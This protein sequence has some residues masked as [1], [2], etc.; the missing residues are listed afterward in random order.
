MDIQTDLN[1]RERQ[2]YAEMTHLIADMLNQLHVAL[3]NVNDEVA[4][5][6]FVIFLLAT[7]SFISELGPI[8]E[9]AIHLKH[10]ADKEIAGV[11]MDANLRA[12][13][14]WGKAHPDES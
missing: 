10:S 5:S 13:M 3:L 8:F 7:Q 6:A 14:E 4:G 12:I 2:R 1:E 9:K 11:D